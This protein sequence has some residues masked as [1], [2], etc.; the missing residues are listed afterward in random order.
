MPIFRHKITGLTQE[1]PEHFREYDFL[2]CVE[3]ANPC[4][5]CAIGVPEPEAEDDPE[6]EMLTEPAPRRVRTRKRS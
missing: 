4:D 2:E 3:T 1:L 6:P 5:H